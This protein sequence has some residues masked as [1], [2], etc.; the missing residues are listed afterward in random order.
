MSHLNQNVTLSDE[1]KKLIFTNA[2]VENFPLL[3]MTDALHEFSEDEFIKSQKNDEFKFVNSSIEYINMVKK[4]AEEEQG[5]DF[6]HIEEI[7]LRN[8]VLRDEDPAVKQKV[9]VRE[10]IILN[11]PDDDPDDQTIV[12]NK[13]V[14]VPSISEDHTL[15][16]LKQKMYARATSKYN[17]QLEDLMKMLGNLQVQQS[18]TD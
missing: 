5:M 16:K 18:S 15:E 13:A 7:H 10:L 6:E 1:A 2:T 14:I 8:V 4:L 9:L 17:S 12:V 3:N 11:T